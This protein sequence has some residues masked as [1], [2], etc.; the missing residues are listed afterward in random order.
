[1]SW[2]SIESSGKGTV[3]SFTIIHHPPVPGYDIPIPVGLVELEEGT[4]IVANLAGCSRDDIHIGMKVECRVEDADETV[5]LP[6][7]YP[8]A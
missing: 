8:A 1:M 2:G 7:F 3:H 6:F 4:R 5:K